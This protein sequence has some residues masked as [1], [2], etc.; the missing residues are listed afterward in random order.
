M[1]SL[2]LL[3]VLIFL[4]SPTSEAAITCSDVISNLRPCISYLT[5][6]SGKPPSPCCAGVSTLST[7][8]T[9]TADKQTACNCIKNASKNLNVNTALAQALPSNCGV[10]LPFTVSPTVDCSK[11]T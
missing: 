11:I 4:L 9:T 5:S 6:G 1:K 8:A 10:S 3:L 2:T 7:S